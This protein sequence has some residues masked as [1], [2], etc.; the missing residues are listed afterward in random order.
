MYK[1]CC[2]KCGS[3]DLFTKEKGGNT[4][5]YCSDCG[6]WIKWLGK[7]ELLAFNES[8]KNVSKQKEEIESKNDFS[9]IKQL[10]DFINFLDK[11]IDNELRRPPL[12]TEDAMVKSAIAM[13][14][15]KDK[16]ALINI[17][18]GRKWNEVDNL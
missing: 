1:N 6:A 18:N 12:S 4:G 17:V 3:T 2:K 8:K 9:I 10:N 14:Y 7:D 11:Q 16:R 13:S 5:L 15:E